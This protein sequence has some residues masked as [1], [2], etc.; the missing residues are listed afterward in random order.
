MCETCYI[1][2]LMFT[3]NI[4]TT[5]QTGGETRFP[6]KPNIEAF[7]SRLLR[8]L[9]PHKHFDDMEPTSGSDAK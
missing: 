1:T 7:M 8:N 9:L 6:S 4:Y 5:T 2:G 3:H